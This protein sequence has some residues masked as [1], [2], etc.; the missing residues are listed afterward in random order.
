[1]STD[2]CK[3]CNRIGLSF[4]PTRIAYVPGEP[5]H[6]P[7]SLPVSAY[8]PTAP[9]QQG[10]YVLRLISEGYVYL[11]DER[12]G[13]VWRCFAA[14]ASG[15][16]R[17]LMLDTAP[18][19]QPAFH[20]AREGHTTVAALISIPRASE[21]G[22]VW[23][24]YSRCWLTASARRKLKTDTALRSKLMIGFDAKQIVQGDDM[25]AGSGLRVRSGSE[26][27]ALLGEYASSA[28]D[29]AATDIRYASHTTR[30]ALDRH[31][32]A[33][34][35]VER[36]HANSPGNAI[37][38]CL[39]DSIGIVQDINHWRNLK[40]GE[41]AGHLADAAKLRERIIGDLILG[42]EA[43]MRQQGQGTLWDERYAP[44]VN[45]R[46]VHDDKNAHTRKLA[47]IEARIL[48]ASEDWC[49]WTASEYFQ[50]AWQL[51]DGADPR[52]GK[53]VGASM[54]RDFTHCVFGSGATPGEQKW[55]EAA[56]G[57]DP[58]DPRHAL[59][60]AFTAADKDL[61]AFLKG[62]A[63]R[64]LDLDKGVDLVKQSK[65]LTE[66]LRE[67]HQS[68]AATGLMRGIQA[69]SGLLASTLAAQLS[70]LARTRPEAALV[71][72]Q[73]LRLVIASRMEQVVTPHIQHIRLRQMV[74]Q[75]HEAV[76]G[77]PKPRISTVVQ[78]ARALRIVQ[79]LDGAWLGNAFSSARAVALEVW[80]PEEAVRLG[81]VP[82]LPATAVQAALPRP[83]LN[84]WQGLTEYLKHSRSLGQGVLGLGAA[85]QISNLATNLI[86]LDRAL[87][88][89][90]AQR[91]DIIT[92]SLYG[93]ASGAL[94]VMA[95]SAEVLAGA[96]AARVVPAVASTTAARLLTAAGWITLWG[97]LL[98]AISAAV[99]G[100]Q[101]ARKAF[102]LGQ[103]GDPDAA[104][105]Y[106]RAS[107]AAVVTTISSGA[108]TVIAAGTL[109]AKAGAT[110]AAASAVIGAASFLGMG[111]TIPVLGWLVLV[112][113]ATT[114]GIYLGYR[115]ATEEDTP[116]EKWL[117]R[118]YWRNEAE[119]ESTARQKFRTLQDE[120]AEFQ[121]AL[122]GIRVTLNWN[123]RIG[124]DEIEVNVVMPGYSRTA[125]E[126]AFM[127]ELC[128]PGKRR[129]IVDRQT[130]AFS[131][132]PDLQPLPPEQR[133]FSAPPP[134]SSIPMEEILEVSSP[135]TLKI[136]EGAAIY[137]GKLRVNEA[138]YNSARLKFEYWPDP[139]NRPELRIT[140]VPGGVNYA[141]A[142]D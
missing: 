87:K 63:A 15:L 136:E 78:E 123:D 12:A 80:L 75:M 68:R 16:F 10:K 65:E 36:M 76:W 138:F 101:S 44:K 141:E 93:V 79:G 30:A 43:A 74:V 31:A 94:G 142:R 98:G 57:A 51:Y 119:Y 110:G 132:D 118:C 40:A 91:D 71:A 27:A 25:P 129:T 53:A 126:Y 7:G 105:S 124:K 77:P 1:M 64:P 26:L 83:A 133:Y 62:D 49:H 121:I 122:Y 14:T 112:I 117:S 58:S 72:G 33:D 111:A 39:P 4:L 9:M 13:G 108:L 32:Q 128:G 95:V 21:V 85:L 29:F 22:K 20:C 97:G 92:Q 54:E 56:L 34:A 106:N 135:F 140:P 66:K 86:Q 24:C 107:Q 89:N 88:G 125:S 104:T 69:E 17:E 103:D 37:V 114:A 8:M 46:A 59:W 55:W 131:A 28:Q 116:L 113:G 38:L 3:F 61:V 52:Q 42:L 5:A 134:E 18:K 130:S 90:A 137:A 50:L 109:L 73:R 47:E 115:A 45:L 100:V 19:E 99:D 11:L 2:D 96:S 35:V 102:S 127:L 48:R 81:S 41:L 139:A 67:W 82:A 6:K 60:L 120:M 84:P 70:L 23:L